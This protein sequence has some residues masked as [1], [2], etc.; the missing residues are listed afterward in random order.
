MAAFIQKL[1]KSRKPSETTKKSSKDPLQVA[2]QPELSRTSLREDQLKTLQDSPTEAVLTELAIKGVTADIR[3]EA[4]SRLTD[5]GS[6]QQVQKQA[7]GRD[8]SV[9][10][11]VRQTLQNIRDDQAI[12]EKL[13]QTITTLI[14]NVRDQASSDNT[15]LY[16]ARLEALVQQWAEVEDHATAEQAQSFLEAAHTCRE[17]ISV[18]QAAL[19]DELRQ[20][21]QKQQRSETLALLTNTLTD[22]K[23]QSPEL[24]PSQAALDALQKTQE[25]RWLEATRDTS[26]E[27]QEQKAYE[28]KMHALR[29][30]L[31]AVRHIGQEKDNLLSL[32]SEQGENKE[33]DVRE[34]AQ[35]LLAIIA[36]PDGYP[37]PEILEPIRKLAGAPPKAAKPDNTGNHE[38]QRALTAELGNSIIKLEAALEAKQ[39]KAS[40]QL[41]KTTQHQLKGLEHRHAK[42]FLAR[43]QLLT[44][45]LRELSDWQGFA[46]EPKQITLCEQMEYLAEQPMEPETK[47][48]HIKK[49]QNEWRELGGTPNRDLWTRF[50]KASDQA[51]LPCKAYFSAKSGLKQA[52]LEKRKTICDELETFLNNVDWTA[53]DWKAVEKIH[54]TAR[55]E[56]K[57]AWPVEFR[58]NRQ[59]QKRFDSLLKQLE[60]PLDQERHRNEALKKKIVEKA[61]ELSDLE[62]LQDAMNQA[63]NLQTEWKAIGITRHREDRKLWQEF[64]KAC[65]VIFARRDAQRNELQQVAAEADEAA[66]VVLDMVSQ[67]KQPTDEESLSVAISHLR[68][69]DTSSL[70]STVREQ[71]QVEKQRLNKL[72]TDIKLRT[73]INQWKALVLARV[74][75][76]LAAEQIP[77]H[78][79]ELVTD[80]EQTGFKE[81][82]IRA[83][84]LGGIASPEADQQFRMEIQV[85]RLA[86]G[87]G[88]SEKADNRL[89]ALEKLVSGWCLRPSDTNPSQSLAERIN[90][91]LTTLMPDQS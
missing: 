31:S 24:L 57:D 1:F 28:S 88:S 70:S 29:C 86:E 33:T 91:A 85:R 82:A 62:P 75:G 16:K 73:E 89:N 67:I 65:D 55:Q 40:K 15:K 90:N 56:W 36:W 18:M 19:D 50:K 47:A 72:T 79:P 51:Y 81:L 78:W 30:Y 23:N 3:L 5:T 87:M 61:I 53:I 37:A 68:E 9:Y 74:N 71:V 77:E 35:T 63:K 66:R 49:L 41:L 54:L 80:R 32:A 2:A 64:R 45:Q 39:L 27:K 69:L 84:I 60:T 58:D 76:A 20:Q 25:N 43:I 46:T 52:N 11:A 8:K 6:L 34:R 7:K 59:T 10:Q 13:S 22:L 26:V 42:P 4:A 38:K 17:R 21:E 44:G 12:T 14:N 48:E 83:E